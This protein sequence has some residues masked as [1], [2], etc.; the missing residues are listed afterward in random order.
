LPCD[1]DAVV[2]CNGEGEITFSDY[3]RELTETHPD[4]GKVAGISYVADGQIV[5]TAGRT[6]T[7]V[8]DEIPSPFLT[9]LFRN[10]YSFS[11]FE[12]N[13]G[14]PFRCGFCYWGAATNDKVIRF[15]DERVREEIE[16]LSRKNV[17]YVF[18]ADANWGITTRDVELTDHIAECKRKYGAPKQLYFSSA[19]NSP[20][21][22]FE[23][24]KIFRDADVLVS[25]PVSLQS[26]SS[27]AL[28]MIDRQNIKKENY[29]KLQLQL[30]ELK[31]SSVTEL[32]WPLPG[33]TL[34]SFKSGI[35]DFCRA[36]DSMIVA[37]AHLL[38]PNTTLDKKR[39]EFGLVT[40]GSDDETTEAELVVATMTASREEVEEGFRY[41]YAAHLLHNAYGLRYWTS[42]L[43]RA[44]LAS[45]QDVFTEFAE[46]MRHSNACPISEYVTESSK[47]RIGVDNRAYGKVIHYAL[48]QHRNAFVELLHRFVSSRPYW[49]DERV[50]TVYELD[51]LFLPYVY[52]STSLDAAEKCTRLFARVC[53]ERA[54]EADLPVWL[55]DLVHHSH[56][57]RDMDTAGPRGR[58]R[59]DHARGQLPITPIQDLEQNSG[60]CYEAVRTKSLVPRCTAVA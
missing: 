56:D 11:V 12:T 60:R 15:S 50:Q 47:G 44:R 52:S 42:Y 27:E 46:F 48:H 26:S 9:G 2:I 14:C 22:V 31:I 57:R 28:R 25:Q 6:R 21:R 19:K 13:R 1:T 32:I 58:Y 20:D 29:I 10:V 59:I 4:W 34:A 41:F 39:Q 8:L 35:D 16:W 36:G 53:A 38:L 40:M 17:W 30:D 49:T 37:Y 24:V 45:Y 51:R 7:A 33:E 55:S 18:I 3:L 23:I 5:T 54:Y 43:D